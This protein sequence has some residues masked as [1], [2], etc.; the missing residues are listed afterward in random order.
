MHATWSAIPIELLICCH[1]LLMNSLLKVKTFCGLL[2]IARHDITMSTLEF[3][4]RCRRGELHEVKQLLSANPGLV[5]VKD[6]VSFSHK[7]VQ[8]EKLCYITVPDTH[9]LH[10]CLFLDSRLNCNMNM[11]DIK[12]HLKFSQSDSIQNIFPIAKK[13]HPVFKRSVIR[14]SRCATV[15]YDIAL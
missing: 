14:H 9:F 2:Y 5:E 15:K 8:W 11:D 1:A 7:K 6:H 4:G 10:V 13:S 3:M 12:L